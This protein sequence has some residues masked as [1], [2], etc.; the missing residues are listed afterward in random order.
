[1]KY[2]E[3]IQGEFIDRPNRFIANVNVNGENQICHVKNTG[4]CKELLIPGVTVYL[5][6]NSNPKR[7]TQ[8]S[9]VAVEKED[10]LINM[11]SQAPNKVVKEWLEQGN[12]F[13]DQARIYPERKFGDSRIDFY[14][15]V[16]NRKI[17]IE[18]KGVTLEEDGVVRFPDAPTMRGIKHI[19]ELVKAKEQ[20]YE[21][22]ILFVVQMNDVRYFVP[23][24]TQQ[25]EFARE[26]MKGWNQ[27]V[28]VMAYD[29]AVSE[30]TLELQHKLP[31]RFSENIPD[32]SFLEKIVDPILKWY[33]ENARVLPWRE[34]P[35]PYRVWISEIML[36]Q[37]RVE[38]VK[39]YYERFIKRLP[40]VKDLAE[41]EDEE[42]MKLWEGLGYYNRARNLKKAANSIMELYKGQLP[43][44]YIELQK[45][46]GIGSYTAGAIGSIAFGLQVPAVDGNVMRVITR[47]TGDEED[48]LKAAMKQ[49]IEAEIKK[50]IPQ[51]YAG[52][53][54]QALME[55]GAMICIPNGIPKCE[56]CPFEEICLGRKYNLL[57]QIPHKEPKKKRKIQK[58][59]VLIIQSDKA[60]AIRKRENHGLLQ[61][62]Y[63]LPNFEEYLSE[64][65]VLE[66]IKQQ[67]LYP[68]RI[69]KLESSKHIF[70]H[71]EWH[72]IGYKIHIEDVENKIHKNMIFVEPYETKDKYPIPSAFIKYTKGIHMVLGS[73][74]F[75][76]E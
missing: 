50:I 26:L 39:P 59:T 7:K 1:M 69:Q 37:T 47:I 22:I 16:E 60:V 76:Q 71:I 4:R 28:Q 52:E 64:D 58:L 55:I 72:M 75:A 44:D 38:A 17:F 8:Y 62:M 11:D 45:L 51:N 36:Q 61:G 34:Q 5:E 40:S 25:P 19:H 56:Q 27:G 41:V 20:G 57:K 65:Q 21:A 14:I 30:D 42:L 12:L 46:S 33:Q 24:E 9:L 15:E 31:V 68:I 73:E 43:A 10:R 3:I 6:H 54:S 13:G 74:Q 48:V 29:C 32:Y 18:V 53:F 66:W 49:K 2:K 63:E 70:T 67:N 35:E 23:N